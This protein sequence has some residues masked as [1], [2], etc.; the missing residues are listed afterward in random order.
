M[1]NKSLENLQ[2]ASL[3]LI[4][5]HNLTTDILTT[6]LLRFCMFLESTEIPVHKVQRECFSHFYLCN[7]ARFV[8]GLSGIFF[9]HSITQN[10]PQIKAILFHSESCALCCS[11]S[12]PS[13]DILQNVISN[14][15]VLFVSHHLPGDKLS[16]SVSLV[17]GFVRF[18]FEMC[19]ND[20]A[21]EY[22][23]VI[24]MKHKID[25]ERSSRLLFH[26]EIRR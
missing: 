7:R 26:R 18:C 4:L 21:K 22:C 8:W 5:A 6:L 19:E 10:E 13:S 24:F 16:L 23:Q 25:P 9:F 12:E 20:L 14:C 17:G 1:C 11:V 3:L 15:H 2:I